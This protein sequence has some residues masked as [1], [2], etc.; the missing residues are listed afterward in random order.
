MCL[1]PIAVS[2]REAAAFLSVSRRTVTNL[3]QRKKIAARKAGTRT[4][5]DVA[6]LKSFYETLPAITGPQPVFAHPI[7]GRRHGPSRRRVR[8]H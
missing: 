8:R 3:I 4:L 6:S 1:E 5:I 7:S 2:P